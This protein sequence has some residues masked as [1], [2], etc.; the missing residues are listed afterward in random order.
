M[1]KISQLLEASALT[2]LESLPIVQGNATRRTKLSTFAAAMVSL[3]GQA[4]KGDP[5]GTADATGLFTALPNQVV[6]VGVDLI[7]VTGTDVL[8]DEGFGREF[9]YD[10]RIDA[11]YVAADPERSVITKNGRGFREWG[12]AR[13]LLDDA[14]NLIEIDAN[15]RKRMLGS[16]ILDHVYDVTADI[17][18]YRATSGAAYAGDQVPINLAY[19]TRSSIVVQADRLGGLDIRDTIK[20]LLRNPSWRVQGGCQSVPIVRSLTMTGHT[21]Q[22]GDEDHPAGA[23]VADNMWFVHEGRLGYGDGSTAYPEGSPLPGVR[24][25]DKQA[26]LCI[27][28]A[29]NAVLRHVGGWGCVHGVRL[30]GFNTVDMYHSFWIG[31]VRDDQNPLADEARSHVCLEY[32]SLFRCHGG[33]FYG[34]NRSA[35][36]AVSV[37][38]KTVMVNRRLGPQYIFLVKACENMSLHGVFAGQASED[39]IG[40]RPVSASA[41]IFNIIVDGWFDE[42]NNNALGSAYVGDPS[43]PIPDGFQVRGY[44]NGQQISQKGWTTYLGPTGGRSMRRFRAMADFRAMLGACVQHYGVDDAD[45]QMS[46]FAG[47]NCAR[48]QSADQAGVV[49][50]GHSRH[51]N[52]AGCAFGGGINGTDEVDSV[53]AKGLS[54]NAV[55][56]GYYRQKNDGVGTQTE[57]I[58]KGALRKLPFGLAGGGISVAEDAFDPTY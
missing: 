38:E 47:Y 39:T 4:W 11:A 8:G 42:S 32:G 14:G 23:V 10:S 43:F 2:G 24:L 13:R 7:R 36:R 51:V 57:N 41:V 17:E 48:S 15:G 20:C 12:L 46:S 55:K 31:G 34:Q 58:T 40:L 25:T 21:F 52:V 50:S 1:G 37:G 45:H 49:A 16:V 54:P 44:V 28:G 29:Q 56:F 26:H 6:P 22:F 9:V 27:Y 19:L 18:D 3:L 35:P 33:S 53:D 30:I 5:G